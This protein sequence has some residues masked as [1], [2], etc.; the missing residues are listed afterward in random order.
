MLFIQVS[1]AVLIFPYK[2]GANCRLN[3]IIGT[4]RLLARLRT[5]I[6]PIRGLEAKPFKGK[7]SEAQINRIGLI[8]TAFRRRQSEICLI[9]ILLVAQAKLET[10]NHCLPE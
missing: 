8:I 3:H 4:I 5:V 9:A 10:L 6:I 1:S 7:M 2:S